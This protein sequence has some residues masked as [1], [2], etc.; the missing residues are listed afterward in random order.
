MK[1][2]IIIAGKG[3][4]LKSLSDSKPLAS[5][6][7]VPLVERVI[8]SALEVGVDGFYAVVGYR[9]DQVR[10]FLEE[11]AGKISAPITV[12]ENDEWEKANGLSV[13]KA[14]EF[15]TEPFFLLMGDHMFDPAIARKMIDYPLAEDEIVL[16]VDE[17]L[18]NPMVDMDDVTRVMA[19]KGLIQ[20]IGKGIEK[21]N[22]FD[23]GIFL[24]NPVL[25]S[26]LEQS[27]RE[28]GNDSL[29]G[30]VHVMAKKDKVRA[31]PIDGRFWIDIDD[32]ERYKQ[33]ENYLLDNS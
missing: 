8:R 18:K 21:Y 7:D 29:S 2:L 31:M 11:L 16:A 22:C 26:A 25:F 30:G 6:L 24:C 27:V 12:I 17:D 20:D 23:T 4:R 32:P 3:S 13:L 15:L 28:T 33:A 10:A 19:E 14:K 1:C 9:G 5:L